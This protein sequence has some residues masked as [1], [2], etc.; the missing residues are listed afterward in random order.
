MSHVPTDDQQWVVELIQ[1]HIAHVSAASQSYYSQTTIT[2]IQGNE[3]TDQ[4]V[5]AKLLYVL[6][7]AKNGFRVRFDGIFSTHVHGRFLGPLPSSQVRPQ[8][9]EAELA[10]EFGDIVSEIGRKKKNGKMKAK[11]RRRMGK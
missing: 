10:E 5:Q 1:R 11:D 6:E 7:E 8:Y 9:E 4:E 3:K 2:V